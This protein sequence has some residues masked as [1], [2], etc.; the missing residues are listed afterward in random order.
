MS[1]QDDIMS[2]WAIALVLVYMFSTAFI[3]LSQSS[4]YSV[5]IHLSEFEL[6]CFLL[7]ISTYG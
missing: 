4:F 1:C 2:C 6:S 3:S 7:Y 5:F